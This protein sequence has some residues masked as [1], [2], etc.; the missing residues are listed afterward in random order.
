MPEPYSELIGEVKH[1][2]YCGAVHYSPVCFA[3]AGYDIVHDEVY[4]S[5]YEYA[6]EVFYYWDSTHVSLF[7]SIFL[8]LYQIVAHVFSV[9]S[10][11][12]VVYVSS[13]YAWEVEHKRY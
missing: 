6:C 13:L 10:S 1:W 3:C 7:I 5:E 4:E 12:A 9:V 11:A 2:L 8:S